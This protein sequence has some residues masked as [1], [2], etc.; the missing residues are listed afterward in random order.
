MD[1]SALGVGNFTRCAL[2]FYSPM[3]YER[4]L[5]RQPSATVV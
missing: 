4:E 1:V 2:C 5:S 3:V